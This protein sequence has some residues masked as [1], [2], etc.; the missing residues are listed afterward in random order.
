MKSGTDGGR[1]V[2]YFL[3]TAGVTILA[4]AGYG[5]Y[6]L[7]P[8]FHLPAVTGIGL[9]ILAASAGIASFF[10]P[11]SFPLLITLLSR[12]PS[13][14]ETPSSKQQRPILFSIALSLGAGIFLL[15][16]GVAVA[17]GGGLFF[18]NITFAST[19]GR[20]IRIVV[21]V[22]LIILGSVQ[23]GLLPYSFHTITYIFK[24]LQKRQAQLRRKQPVLGYAFFGFI[25]LI[26]GFG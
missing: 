8:R 9:L 11:C 23:V 6:V 13:V 20:L 19:A 21:G 25:Y 15:L 18:K 24:P 16:T 1:T 3:L 10:S 26:A 4:V 22:I 14:R 17:L 5:G 12:E 7:Y 2:W